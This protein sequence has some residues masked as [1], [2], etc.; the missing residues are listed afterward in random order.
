MERDTL[1]LLD[2]IAWT[3]RLLVTYSLV[4]RNPVVRIDLTRY[5]GSGGRVIRL[6]RWYKDP[7]Q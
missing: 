2:F 4:P 7:G 5:H 1:V 3:W 6:W